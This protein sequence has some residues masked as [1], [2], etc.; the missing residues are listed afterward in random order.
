MLIFN[1]IRIFFGEIAIHQ[2]KNMNFC[3]IIEIFCRY[4]F[5]QKIAST[6]FCTCWFMVPVMNLCALWAPQIEWSTYKNRIGNKYIHLISIA[7]GRIN[8]NIQNVLWENVLCD[9]LLSSGR[10]RKLTVRWRC[11]H[12]SHQLL[13]FCTFIINTTIHQDWIQNDLS[14]SLFSLSVFRKCGGLYTYVRVLCFCFSLKAFACGFRLY[15][16]PAAGTLGSLKVFWTSSHFWNFCFCA[17]EQ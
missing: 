9:L 1:H 10:S 13:Q 7:R 16:L 6:N 14:W 8:K 2:M 11:N 12:Q 4:F 17:F 3:F 5:W 15:Q